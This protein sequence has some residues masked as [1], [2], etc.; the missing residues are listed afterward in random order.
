MIEEGIIFFSPFPPFFF[1]L[2]SHRKKEEGDASTDFKERQLRKLLFFS[3]FLK[4]KRQKKTSEILLSLL[5]FPSSPSPSGRKQVEQSKKSRKRKAF[6]SFL[7]DRRLWRYPSFFF[8]P[9]STERRRR[10]F[11][12]TKGRPV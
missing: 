7:K 4:G 5:F 10:R 2:P 3:N 8:P 1:P 6:S 11:G 9:F 12:Q